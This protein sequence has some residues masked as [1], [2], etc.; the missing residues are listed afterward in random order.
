MIPFFLQWGKISFFQ[1]MILQS[2]FVISVF[3]L[4]IPTEA[5]ADYFGRKTSLI[6]SAF[7]HAIAAIIYAAFPSFFLFILAEIIWALGVALMSGADQALVYDSL[8]KL[9][10]EKTS[11][12][13][14]GRVTSF[15]VTAL[16]IAAPIGSIIATV[17]GLRYTMLFMAIPFFIASFISLF[18]KEPVT[19]KKAK[20]KN[21][22]KTMIEGVKYFKSHAVLRIL[23]FDLISNTVLWFFIIWTYQP[24]LTQLGVPILFFGL[25]QAGIAGVQIPVMNNFNRLEKL[26]GSKKGLIFWSALLIGVSYFLLGFI[27]YLPIVIL[28]FFVIVGFGGPREVLF[29]N[30]MNK[31]IKSDTRAT[32]L[33][34][35]S[36]LEKLCFAVTYPIVGLLVE[37]SLNTTFVILGICVLFFAV[38]SKVEEKHLID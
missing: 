29:K 6:I 26:F 8:K 4:E 15:D 7:T 18:F 11:K 14:F 13:V 36:M 16:M 37:W 3:L 34:T 9:K 22:L 2:I 12:K 33:S 31:H 23:A 35:V 38:I 1:I 25:V 10:K 30:Y 19:Q 32:V 27:T 21:Y 24:L 5:I 28:L 20:P 17:F